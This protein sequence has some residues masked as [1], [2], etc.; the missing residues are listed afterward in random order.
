MTTAYVPSRS[1]SYEGF[2]PYGAGEMYIMDAYV[3]HYFTGNVT[4]ELVKNGATWDA[5]RRTLTLPNGTEIPFK[6]DS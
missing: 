2:R 4:E 3:E 6:V 1:Y 5:E